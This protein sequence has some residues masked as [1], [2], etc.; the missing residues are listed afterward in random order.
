MKWTLGPKPV[1]EVGNKVSRA[2]TTG[3]KHV[4]TKLSTFSKSF[5][6]Q[7]I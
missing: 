7:N 5:V 4:M 2:S 6:T 3:A 1:D